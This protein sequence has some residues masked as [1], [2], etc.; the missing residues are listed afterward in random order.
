M[1]FFLS[2]NICVTGGE[3]WVKV[4]GREGL[5]IGTHLKITKA[6]TNMYALLDMDSRSKKLKSIWCPP[7]KLVATLAVT[8]DLT[9]RRQG[10]EIKC[11]WC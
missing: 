1:V 9:R 2:P 5:L 4:K 7:L 10:R 6:V 11:C 3:G 8:S